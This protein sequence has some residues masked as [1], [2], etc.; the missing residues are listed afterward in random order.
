MKLKHSIALFA[1]LTSCVPKPPN[2]PVC[3]HLN[4]RIG[5]NIKT[6][7]LVLIPSPTCMNNI[8]EP[9]CGYCTY[10]L[11]EKSFFVGE[12]KEN[13]FNGKPWSQLKAESILVP[14]K[15]SYAPLSAYI[16]NSCKQMNCN[17]DV[18]KF[19]VKLDFLTLGE[20]ERPQTPE[21]D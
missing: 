9:E 3:K 6:G 15:E 14:A 18:T 5:T 10:I 16:I 4:Q 17:D 11:N 7:H 2:V 20:H 12:K 1:C 8:K 19:K 13:H 21:H